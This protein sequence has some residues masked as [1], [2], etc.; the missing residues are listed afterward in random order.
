MRRV[1][2]GRV[3]FVVCR[4]CHGPF[5][6]VFGSGLRLDVLGEELIVGVEC[7]GLCD[8]LAELGVAACAQAMLSSCPRL[9]LVAQVRGC[10]RCPFGR[11]SAP[12]CLV[13]GQAF[14]R[15]VDDGAGKHGACLSLDAAL[16]AAE[17]GHVAGLQ[18]RRAVRRD[19]AQHDV[20]ERRSHGSQSVSAG[21]DAGHVPEKDPRLSLPAW[22]KHVVQSG[23]ELQERRRR[24]PAVLR[25]D[26]A[27]VLRQGLLRQDGVCLASVHDLH[28]HVQR[29][30]VHAEADCE[31][32]LLPRVALQL[33]LLHAAAAPSNVMH[34]EETARGLV[35]VHDAVC[36]DSVLVH[37]P[38][39]LDEEPVRVGVLL[40][41][42]VELFQALGELLEAQAHAVEEPSDP[43]FAGMHVEFF[44]VESFEHQASDRHRAQ[45]QHVGHLHDVL[46]QP[47]RVR[48]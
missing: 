33:S 45:A 31:C 40:L 25:C 1:W 30:T 5:Q 4:L 27:S 37:E 11:R 12:P 42:A 20:W 10:T 35:D 9:V 48:G 34:R 8:G 22:I 44:C 19:E 21:V 17:D 29:S 32:R 26:V 43:A 14:E 7:R 24:G 36:A 41:R 39:Q 16:E 6:G 3:V 18:V 15:A 23:R 38:A 46:A 28:E 13:H 47:C 2:H